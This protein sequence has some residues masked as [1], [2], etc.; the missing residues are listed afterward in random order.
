VPSGDTNP[1]SGKRTIN[2]AF[3]TIVRKADKDYDK[4][5]RWEPEYKFSNGREFK[6]VRARRGAY[7]P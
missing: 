7:T 5:A 1:R 3:R 6:A 2:V 4:D